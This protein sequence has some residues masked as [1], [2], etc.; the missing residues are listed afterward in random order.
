MSINYTY[1]V[2]GAT[3]KLGG[4]G[5]I[6]I[7][8][9]E[10]VGIDENEKKATRQFATSLNQLVHTDSSF[11]TNPTDE[12][13]LIWAKEQWESE[14]TKGVNDF[15]YKECFVPTLAKFE[16]AIK[17]EIETGYA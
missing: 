1:N 3:E 12:Q 4:N 17:N 11:I 5:E 10:I 16:E 7:V 13:K 6:L 8:H 9:V 15:D 14:V 2:L